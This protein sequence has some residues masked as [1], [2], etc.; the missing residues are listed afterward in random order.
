MC[1]C[2][3][4]FITIG[5]LVILSYKKHQLHFTVVF[6]QTGFEPVSLL[7]F[8]CDRMVRGGSG[9]GAPEAVKSDSAWA[10]TR[11]SLAL[12]SVHC[13][14]SC[15]ALVSFAQRRRET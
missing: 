6:K 13:D 2:F 1:L 5:T 3:T 11:C 10:K 15:H 12:M 14:S 8:H 4:I 9:G 7:L